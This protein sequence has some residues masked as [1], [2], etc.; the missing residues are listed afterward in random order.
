[1]NSGASTP[2]LPRGER[3]W[4]LLRIFFLLLGLTLFALLIAHVGVHTLLAQARRIG[5]GFLAI[6]AIFGSVH[7]LRALTWQG[8]LREQGQGL[9]FRAVFSL[10]VAGEAV[11]NLS[12]AWSGEVFRALGARE[13]IEVERSFSALLISR[14]F[15]VYASLIWLTLGLAVLCWAVPLPGALYTVALI[16]IVIAVAILLLATAALKGGGSILVPITTRLA[17]AERQQRLLAR[18]LSFLRILE[19]DLTALWAQERRRFIYLLSLNLLAALVGVF[20]VYIVLWGLDVKPTFLA[21]FIIEGLSKLLAV[22]AFVVPS[23][24]GVREAGTILILQLFQ[25]TAVTGLNLALI[26]RARALVWVGV[27]T[28]LLIRHGLRP[29]ALAAP[30]GLVS[31]GASSDSAPVTQEQLPATKKMR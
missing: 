25:L 9:P 24:L 4:P 22:F 29:L 7:I 12:F 3:R 10:W 5:W 30:R 31:S 16:G 20:E 15:Y 26:R 14:A 8:C 21:A 28:L 1:M 23:N 17:R 13:A 27:G 19:S 2:A 11:A 18:L 6:V